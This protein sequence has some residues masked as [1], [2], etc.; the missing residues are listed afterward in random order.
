MQSTPARILSPRFSK[1]MQVALVR[2]VMPSFSTMPRIASE[3]SSSSLG[4][5]RGARCRIVT[6]TAK[7]AIHLPELQPDVAAANDDQMFGQEIDVYHGRVGEV[8][9]LVET[10]HGR[11]DSAAANVDEDLLGGE[12]VVADRDD[13]GGLEARLPFIDGNVRLVRVSGSRRLPAKAAGSHP[14]ALSPS[15]CRPKPARC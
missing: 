13:V 3:M 1:L 14:C 2:T 10:G 5:R 9:D 6:L 4:T 7:A 8:G 12:T 15:S 11:D